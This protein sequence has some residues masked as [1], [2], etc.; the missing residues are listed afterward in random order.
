MP[1]CNTLP[2]TIDTAGVKRVARRIFVSATSDRSLDPR[3]KSVKAAI[4]RRLREAGYAPQAF[5]ELGVAEDLSWNFANV[6]QV[7][8]QCVGAVVIGFPRW[9]LSYGGESARLVGEYH[10][11]EGAVALTLGLPTLL[12]AE[13]GVENRGVMWEGGG[14]VI[15]YLPDD[16][17]ADWVDGE[18]FSR[19][20]AGWQ[21]ELGQRRDVFLGY[22]G[23][24]RGLA[25]QV[26][27]VLQRNGATVLDW[28]VDFRGGASILGEIERARSMCTCGIFLFT[29]DDPLEGVADGAAPRD[30]VVFEAGHFI[31][32]KGPARCLIIREG[33][34]KMPADL[35]GSIYVP[36]AR[37]ADVD[38][39]ESRLVRFLEKNL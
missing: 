4:V 5:W 14:Q 1:R 32:S 36:L 12:I 21:R 16:A 29:E 34:A 38:T 19:R 18:G 20:F 7:M 27:L 30:N 31:A 37:G 25:A 9:V 26:Q 17:T 13:R 6:D 3:R 23:R 39:I 33:G 15:T 11:F 2:Y 22:C 24:S 10:H 35:G 28:A 8:R